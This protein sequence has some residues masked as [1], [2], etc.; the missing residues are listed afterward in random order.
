MFLIYVPTSSSASPWF[1][2]DRGPPGIPGQKGIKLY[3][4]GPKELKVC[5]IVC[6]SLM[7]Q[8]PV[9]TNVFG[10][11]FQGEPGDVGLKGCQGFPVSPSCL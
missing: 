3:A 1:Q 9:F 11:V 8:R 2:G 6:L 5:L 10:V 4:E 7:P